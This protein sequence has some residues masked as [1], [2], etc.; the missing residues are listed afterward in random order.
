MF[1]GG[2]EDPLSPL[3]Q[4]LR[5]SGAKNLGTLTSIRSRRGDEES[6]VTERK[7]QEVSQRENRRA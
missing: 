4:R 1:H 5:V 7:I 2:T 6:P 3:W